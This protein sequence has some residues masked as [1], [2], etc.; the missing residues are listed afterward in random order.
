ME[1][2]T[3]LSMTQSPAFAF[4]SI[5]ALIVTVVLS[6]IRRD[7]ATFSDRA[8]ISILATLPAVLA[9]FV[10]AYDYNTVLLLFSIAPSFCILMMTS[11]H[12][13][14]PTTAA[15]VLFS[16]SAVVGAIATFVIKILYS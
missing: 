6:L 15:V 8:V 10:L 7:S 5:C 4:V 3:T 11:Q 1:K 2:A 16:L 12:L 13:K 14:I 9:S